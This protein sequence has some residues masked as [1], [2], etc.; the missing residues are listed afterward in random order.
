[1]NRWTY[2][3]SYVIGSW[4]VFFTL[5]GG[6]LLLSVWVGIFDFSYLKA[7]WNA[8]LYASVGSLIT[9]I[10]SVLFYPI[11]KEVD[12]W[13]TGIEDLKGKG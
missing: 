10:I 11:I 3:I 6:V 5:M 8:F 4:I 9:Y 2:K 12:S 13:K 1:M 7:L